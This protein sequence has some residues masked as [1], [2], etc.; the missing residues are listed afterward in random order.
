[1]V[2]HLVMMTTGLTYQVMRNELLITSGM[3]IMSKY[4]VVC[5]YHDN[6]SKQTDFDDLREA[7]TFAD[8]M[9]KAGICTFGIQN[10]IGGIGDYD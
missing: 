10:D 6:S 2:A 3:T 4:S 8:K 5:I 9:M 1:M 7:E